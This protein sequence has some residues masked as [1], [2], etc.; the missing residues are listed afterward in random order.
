MLRNL[1]RSLFQWER[2]K[3]T[4]AKAKLLRPFAEHLITKA[5]SGSVHDRR[6]VL[7]VIQDRDVVHKLFAEIGPR[8]AGRHGGYTRVLK[9]GP[10]NGDGAAMAFVELV[11]AGVARGGADAATGE[12][13]GRRR[14][15]RPGRR[16]AAAQETQEADASGRPPAVSGE[17]STSPDAEEGLEGGQ[18]GGTEAEQR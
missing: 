6:Q 16:R 7:S 9:T 1:A 4:E 13:G 3:T 15:R 8:Y 14:V 2:I 18:V 11:E 12:G 5:K 17:T 10:R